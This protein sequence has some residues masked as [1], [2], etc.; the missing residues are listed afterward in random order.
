MSQPAPGY[1]NW[2]PVSVRSPL[3]EVEMRAIP[4]RYDLSCILWAVIK[5]YCLLNFVSLTDTEHPTLHLV[6][7]RPITKPQRYIGSKQTY[8]T[9]HS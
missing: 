7:Y 9:L 1:L 2:I 3:N 6:Q 8:T 4:S 5:I